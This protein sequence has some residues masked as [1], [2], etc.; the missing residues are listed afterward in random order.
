MLSA[1]AVDPPK[2][3]RAWQC[4]I[5]ALELSPKPFLSNAKRFLLDV[6]TDPVEKELINVLRAN[7]PRLGDGVV[8]RAAASRAPVQVRNILEQRAYAPRRRQILERFCFRASLAVPLV[9]EDRIIGGLVVRRKP[10][11]ECHLEMIELEN[12]D[13]SKVKA[14]CIVIACAKLI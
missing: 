8:G 13:L 1:S 11:G 14:G 7:S 2:S 9:R 10:S 12:L 4:V 5:I 6:F 3:S